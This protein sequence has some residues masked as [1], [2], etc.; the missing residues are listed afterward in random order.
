MPNFMFLLTI[1]GIAAVVL[2][3]LGFILTSLYKRATK[4]KAFVRTGMGGQKV[5]INGGAL[6]IPTFHET[7][8]INMSTQK[9]EIHRNGADALLTKDKMRMDVAAAFYTRVKPDEVA[10]ATAAQTLGK[11]TMDPTALKALVE[12]KFVD[13]LRSVAASMDMADLNTKRAEFSAAVQAAIEHDLV[14]NGLEL[15]NVSITKLDQ[16]DIKFLNENNV[17]DAEGLAAISAITQAKR[18]QR[19]DI[20]QST[21]IEIEQRN[22]EANQKSLSIKQQ[23]QFATLD[24][25]REV[26][27]RRAEQ[28]SQLVKQRA[29]RQR[30]ADIATIEAEQA[31]T[32]ARTTAEQ[33]QKEAGILAAQN[34]RVAEQL[35]AI[36]VN[37]KSEAESKAKAS[38]DLARAEAVKAA[39]EVTTAEQIAS[40]E[41]TKR[42][43]IIAAQQEAER[44]AAGITIT[45]KAEFDA[46][47]LQSK[48]V[49]IRAEAQQKENEV[50]AAGERAMAEA[51]N[52]LSADQVALRIRLAAIEAAPKI[53]A[54]I[55]KP[56]ASVQ[57]ARIVSINGV[58]ANGAVASQGAGGGN[59]PNQLTSAL[60]D[61]RL[62][63]PMVDEL[64]K[65]VGVDLSK[66]LNGAVDPKAFG[67]GDEREVE[68]VGATEI[69]PD[70]DA[71]KKLS[72][73]KD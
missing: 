35:A 67:L 61:Y 21:R 57:G 73:I 10:I 62:Q 7:Q 69:D 6:I 27:T 13:A 42:V 71:M 1:L 68:T 58:G 47:E 28:E 56:M 22:F 29:D 48:A 36:A 31:T 72:G 51:A 34:I 63:G 14:K 18:R 20:E 8:E 16:T 55:A 17:F 54:E 3:V 44:K 2:I 9:L 5:V 64:G 66:G 4:E 24:Q 32:L 52:S 37:E 59:V 38:A 12:D 65:L 25:E 15:E 50:R 43:A 60:L 45:A 70:I 53:L 19:N 46:A 40:A 41:R 39:Q 49:M 30:E 33:K 26:E 23:D 11:V